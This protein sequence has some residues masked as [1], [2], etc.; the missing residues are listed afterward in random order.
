MLITVTDPY[1]PDNSSTAKPFVLQT[2]ASATGIGAVLKQVGQVV[3]YASCVLTPSE[4][5]YSVI[6]QECLAIVYALKQFKH[7]LLG[8]CFTFQTDHAPLQWLTSQMM[9]GLLCRWALPCRNLIAILSIL[10]YK[11]IC[12]VPL[13]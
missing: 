4:K 2:D 1:F 8:C 12:L 6:Q 10:E 3:A 11:C 5:S 13:P 7:Y 9:E